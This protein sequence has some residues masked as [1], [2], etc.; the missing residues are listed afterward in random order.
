VGSKTFCRNWLN[1]WKPVFMRCSIRNIVG[2]SWLKQFVLVVVITALYVATASAQ[3]PVT[4]KSKGD[5][6]N[7]IDGDSAY[8]ILK[9]ICDLGPRISGSRAMQNQQTMLTEYFEKLGATVH[10]QTFTMLHPATREDTEIG[11]LIVEFYPDRE[12]RV[13]ICT[14]YDT[15]PFPD[16]DP[17]NPRGLFLG[18]NDGASGVGLLCELGRHVTKLDG[19]VGLDFV[20]FDAEEFIYDRNRDELFVGSTHFATE[21]RDNPPN[22]KYEAAVLIDMIGDK[23]LD[24]FYEKNSLKY[25]PR[26]TKEIWQVAGD[27]DI[28]EFKAR[29]RHEVRDDHLPLNN[30][31][32]IPTCD[33]IDFDY[34]TIRNRNIYWHTTDDT[35]DKCSA[36]S[37]AKVGWVLH[38]WIKKRI[39]KSNK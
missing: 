22:H 33:I 12:K 21:Y 26:V 24:L 36:E 25:A 37:L 18:A 35:V 31:A 1:Y 8:S 6:K 38:V 5:D 3:N 27:L 20:F 32:Q 11:N 7:P 34:P 14:H 28:S 4:K 9:Q 23:H 2:M 13:M 30:I 29:A 17:T 19:D 10:L 15:R 39:T 16:R